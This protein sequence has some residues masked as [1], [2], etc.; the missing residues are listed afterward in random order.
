MTS[1]VEVL[2]TR[3]VEGNPIGSEWKIVSIDKLAVDIFETK[4]TRGSSYIER[5]EHILQYNPKCGL[6]NIRNDD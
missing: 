3:D 2:D 6:I 4:P 1:K 5:P